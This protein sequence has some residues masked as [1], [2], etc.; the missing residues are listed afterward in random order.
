MERVAIALEQR[1]VRVHTAAGFVAEGLRHERGEQPLLHR[2]FLDNEPERHEVVGGGQGV[3][4]AQVDLLL[5]G[6]ALVVTELDR[7]PHR[8]QG[9]DRLSTEVVG[10][11]VRS[12]VEV[13]VLVDRLGDASRARAFLEQVE[14]DLG[15]GVEAETLVC[16]F[17]QRALENVTRIG[18]RR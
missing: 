9:C 7:D 15:V 10:D 6:S 3:R 5:P 4:V 11:A 18:V 8:F 17:R 1:Q 13:A 16:G 12:V 14:L 2:D